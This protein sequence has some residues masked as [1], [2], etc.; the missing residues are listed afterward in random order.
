MPP[1]VGCIVNHFMASFVFYIS[2][3]ASSQAITSKHQS[4][5]N[6]NYYVPCFRSKLNRSIE[7]H[8]PY[9]TPFNLPIVQ[10]SSLSQLMSA[11]GHNEDRDTFKF[12]V[13]S[14]SCTPAHGI[15][16]NQHAAEHAFRVDVNVSIQQLDRQN[17]AFHWYYLCADPKT[18]SQITYARTQNS[19]SYHR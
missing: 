18:P 16:S 7:S 1:I 5:C 14:S 12:N 4:N 19:I 15:A 2:W 3:I 6:A 17:E 13:V 10:S 11:S 8:N 9:L